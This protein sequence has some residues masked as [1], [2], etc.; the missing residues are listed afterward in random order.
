MKR[1]TYTVVVILTLQLFIKIYCM[2]RR[3]RVV[4]GTVAEAR[5]DRELRRFLI[6]LSHPTHPLTMKPTRTVLAAVTKGVGARTPS[7]HFLGPRHFESE[8]ERR[9]LG[10]N[11][12]RR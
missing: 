11:M 4:I 12:D 7:I 5:A 1:L 6:Q 8:G 9:L 3:A 2:L 10:R